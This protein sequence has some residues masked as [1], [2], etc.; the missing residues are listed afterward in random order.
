MQ[1]T[2]STT[3]NTRTQTG[4]SRPAANTSAMSDMFTTL[5][6][7]QIKN[8][9]PL[10]PSDPSQFVN[11]LAQLSQTE[12]LQ[13]LASLTS[14]NATVLQSMQMLALG[15]QVGSNVMVE[16]DSV[17]LG[18]T[19]VQGTVTLQNATTSATL[20]LTGANGVKH[21]IALGSNAAGEVPF[22]IDPKALGLPEGRYSMHVDTASGETPMIA[23]AGKL[24]SVKLT[25]EG[26]LLN[27]DNAGMVTPSAI[28]SFNGQ[29]AAA[30]N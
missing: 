11:Q 5:L 7:A 15:A 18:K 12:A 30:S 3:T 28:L 19:A 29:S 24:N 16:S 22:S 26:A 20:V 25:A 4:D 23:L 21:S 1:T 2:S 8:Q 6:V 9:D 27:V 14:N 17:T 13:N 10:A